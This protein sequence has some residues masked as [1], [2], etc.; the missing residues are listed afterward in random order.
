M[1]QTIMVNNRL[2]S[3]MV[4]DR[5][6]L[7]RIIV[8]RNLKIKTSSSYRAIHEY[9]VEIRIIGCELGDVAHFRTVGLR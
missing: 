7:R 3:I 2:L 4:N 5:L 6:L 1:K 9:Q 8:T